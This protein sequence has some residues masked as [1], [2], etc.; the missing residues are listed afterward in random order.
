MVAEIIKLDL[1]FRALSDQDDEDADTDIDDAVTPDSGNEK[2]DPYVD[3]DEEKD[4]AEDEPKD[5]GGLEE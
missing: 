5:T 1:A 4:D 2:E 3:G